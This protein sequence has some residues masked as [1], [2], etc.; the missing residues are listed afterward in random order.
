MLF[1]IAFHSVLC[2]DKGQSR[3]LSGHT[4][5]HRGDSSVVTRGRTRTM[6]TQ[7][8]EEL[9]AEGSAAFLVSLE[10]GLQEKSLTSTRS[11]KIAM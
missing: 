4:R 1:L 6:K 3:Q 8:A 7:L 9:L 11:N 5:P 2:P 10:G